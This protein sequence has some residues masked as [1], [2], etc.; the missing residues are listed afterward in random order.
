MLHIII[1]FNCNT[2]YHFYK[3]YTIHTVHKVPY[4]IFN[5]KY[6]NQSVTTE[7]LQFKI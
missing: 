3:L 7:L 1:Q 5:I 6:Y 2:I 4:F